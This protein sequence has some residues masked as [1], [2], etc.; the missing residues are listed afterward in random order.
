MTKG[1]VS[2]LAK[3]TK[4]RRERLKAG[5]A[6]I[7]DLSIAR[8]ITD[9]ELNTLTVYLGM[10]SVG[11]ILAYSIIENNFKGTSASGDN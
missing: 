2:C 3:E 10:L 9:G 7:E 11:L 8:M 4:K 1:S 5:I 6:A